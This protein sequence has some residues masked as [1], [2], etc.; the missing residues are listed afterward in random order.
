LDDEAISK[1]VKR[2]PSVLCYSID[3]NLEPK[4]AW[5]KKRLGL[6]D[7]AIGKLVK[8]KP[9][10]LGYS[11]E[12]NLEPKLE[13]LQKR[14]ALDDASLSDVVRRMPSVLG[15]NIET[16]MEPTITFYED[17]LGSDAA[18]TFIVN[19]PRVLNSSLEK[20]LKPRLAECQEA[21]IPIDKGTT[22]RMA[23]YSEDRWSISMAY[24]KRKL[25]T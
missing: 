19:S 15:L 8:T 7:E 18:I 12:Q 10:V 4:I 24:Q 14:L 6:D 3:D 16:N 20:R 21:G 1:L 9:A 17:C 11:I 2:L 25:L 13:W 5:L 23:M 22:E